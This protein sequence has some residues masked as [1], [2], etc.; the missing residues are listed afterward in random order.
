MTTNELQQTTKFWEEEPTALYKD[1]PRTQV[2]ALPIVSEAIMTYTCPKGMEKAALAYLACVI[3]DTDNKMTVMRALSS[4]VSI[5]FSDSTNFTGSPTPP[6]ELTGLEGFI[7][8]DTS[9]SDEVKTNFAND[10][11]LRHADVD[12]YLEC[13]IDELGG[14]FGDL[15]V[16][17]TKRL[18]PQ[19]ATA[20]NERRLNSVL[21][22]SSKQPLIFVPGSAF[23]DEKVLNKVYAAFTSMSAIR[24]QLIYKT[25]MKMGAIRFGPS[26]TFSALFLLL[27][28]QGLG[29]LKVIREAVMKH[30]EVVKEFPE[31]RPE[32][33]AAD[34]GIKVVRSVETRLR[35]FIKAIYG[36]NFVPSSQ[37]DIANLL[38]VAKKIMV[39][40]SPNYANFRGG[41]TTADQDDRIA[42][43]LKKITT[44]TESV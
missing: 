9:S 30:P 10:V 24:C 33:E 19:N 20:F 34:A 11:E 14:Y 8:G 26:V 38:G 5:I 28:D 42:R 3:K 23:L 4:A 37:Q 22:A 31:L 25:A 27:V 41:Y 16:A 17:G 6:E 1:K 21:A 44:Q 18:T 13:D 2:P 15:F 29:T 12:K 40:Y 32:L 35:P 7:E 43:L 39:E 36:Q